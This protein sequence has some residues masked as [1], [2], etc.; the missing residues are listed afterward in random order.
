MNFNITTK[1]K[2][3]P[4]KEGNAKKKAVFKQQ[5]IYSRS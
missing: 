4:N 5:S 2:V 1:N 3:D